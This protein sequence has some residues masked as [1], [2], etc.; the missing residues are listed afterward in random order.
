L[1]TAGALAYSVE[2]PGAR[3]NTSA[4]GNLITGSPVNFDYVAATDA[5]G[6]TYVRQ[7]EV[8]VTFS[9]PYYYK[10]RNELINVYNPEGVNLRTIIAPGIPLDAERHIAVSPDAERIFTSEHNRGRVEVLDGDG[11]VKYPFGGFGTE[12][13]RFETI[14]GL[15]VNKDGRVYVSDA[16]AGRVQYFEQVAVT[17]VVDVL[18]FEDGTFTFPL[19]VSDADGDTITWV[20]VEGPEDGVASGGTTVGYVPPANFYG[21]V[22]FVVAAEDGFGGST[23]ME[24]RVA[25]QPANDSPVIEQGND[26]LVVTM[27][28]NGTPTAFV[29]PALSATDVED[30]TLTWSVE[31]RFDRLIGRLV[32]P[33]YTAGTIGGSGTGN[34]F[35]AYTYSPKANYVGID[36]F[37]VRVTDTS[38]HSD[39]IQV[40]VT[41]VS[42]AGALTTPDLADDLE[43]NF[44]GVD[45]D[46]SG[47]LS[48]TEVS[49][50]YPDIT[51]AQFNELDT[52]GDGLLTLAEI[53]AAEEPEA[54]EP[55]GCRVPGDPKAFAETAIG[56]L[57]NVIREG[58][59]AY[60]G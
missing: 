2:L 45:Q 17:D 42:T 43:L 21:N 37:V 4:P 6:N 28:Q 11:V 51:V 55:V 48:R 35:S 8:K 34:T 41:V 13:G 38:G 58:L 50:V 39:G 44:Q 5:A 59:A 47:T 36:T 54:E 27:S 40:R 18:M 23:A 49:E 1:S 20:V 15:A 32:Y 24:V 26:P 9:T 22:S 31:N 60:I 7:Q 19:S 53:R 52:N 33:V 14:S 3:D 29:V 57:I 56:K 10:N 16:K 12:E 30:D 25:V 46:G